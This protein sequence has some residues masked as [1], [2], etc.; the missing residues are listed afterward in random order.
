MTGKKVSVGGNDRPDQLSL[1]I[2]GSPDDL[3]AGFQL[4]HALLTEGKLEESALKNWRKAKLEAL[5]EGR[6][7]PRFQL[8][9]NISEVLA[10]VDPRLKMLEPEQVER[11]SLGEAQQWFDRIRRS[12]P[13]EIAVVGDMQLAPAMDLVTKYLGSLPNRPRR[14]DFGKLRKID[15]GD[16]PHIRKI[17]VETMTPMAYVFAGFLSCEERDVADARALHLAANVLTTRMV[18]EIREEKQLVYSIRAGSMPSRAYRDSGLFYAAAPTDPEKSEQLAQAIFETFDTFAKEGPSEQEL[19]NAKKQVAD[20]LDKARKRPGYWLGVLA[21][22]TYHKR[23]LE[24]EKQEEEA[25]QK[26]TAEE[27]AG[28]FRK[29]YKPQRHVRVIVT[30]ADTKDEQSPRTESENKPPATPEATGAE[31]TK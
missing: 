21:D 6:T 13:I 17:A 14:A 20:N 4:A 9:K 7:D 28:A 5:E 8:S 27:V 16:G 29:Y 1:S 24:D 23:S 12:A 2:S 18:K 3:E 31:A 25:Y 22:L 26:M 19:A 10:G 30:P 15:R 11:Q